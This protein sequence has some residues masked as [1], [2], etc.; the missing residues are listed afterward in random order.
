MD[1]LILISKSNIPGKAWVIVSV[2]A[3]PICQLM[4][5]MALTGLNNLFI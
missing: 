4:P 2:P 5:K 1:T 3:P